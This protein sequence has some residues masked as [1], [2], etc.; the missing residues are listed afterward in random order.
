MPLRA[1]EHKAHT[2]KKEMG[3]QVQ[4][5]PDIPKGSRAEE[6]Q[7]QGQA[8]KAKQAWE[9]LTTNQAVNPGPIAQWSSQ[10]GQHQGEKCLSNGE[11]VKSMRQNG[12]SS[13]MFPAQLTNHQGGFDSL[14]TTG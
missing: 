7:P 5:H 3:E 1:A 9:E 10:Q 6:N 4:H 14:P 12:V 13:K 8:I 2:P 11:K